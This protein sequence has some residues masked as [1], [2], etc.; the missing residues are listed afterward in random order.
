[1][2]YLVLKNPSIFQNMRLC[3][4]SK[5]PLPNLENFNFSVSWIIFY[6]SD[7]I[8]VQSWSFRKTPSQATWY[9]NDPWSKKYYWFYRNSVNLFYAMYCVLHCTCK[10]KVQKD[11]RMICRQEV[12]TMSR[13]LIGYCFAAGSMSSITTLKSKA[14]SDFTDFLKTSSGR[15]VQN[16]LHNAISNEPLHIKGP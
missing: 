13:T 14:S 3:G 16:I 7:Q 9:M 15:R 5:N 6:L 1:M 4:Q 12:F 2:D 10:A 11:T 8:S